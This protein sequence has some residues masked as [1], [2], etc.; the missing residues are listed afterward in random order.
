MKSASIVDLSRIPGV[1]PS[2]ASDLY[3]LGIRE[4]ADLRGGDPQFL[5]SELCRKMNQRVDRC[6]L[7]V[8]RCAVYFASESKHDPELLKWWNWKDG[9]KAAEQSACQDQQ[10]NPARQNQIRTRKFPS[11]SQ[12][13]SRTSPART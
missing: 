4:V 13:Q 5:Y 6:V 3:S 2:I 10:T 7:Y 12:V 9:T 8:F 1:G 11:L